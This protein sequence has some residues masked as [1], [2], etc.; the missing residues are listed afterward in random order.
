MYTTNKTQPYVTT[1]AQ[2]LANLDKKLHKHLHS[3]NWILVGFT[4]NGTTRYRSS[5]TD[6]SNCDLKNF[7]IRRHSA[8]YRTFTAKWFAWAFLWGIFVGLI[9]YYCVGCWMCVNYSQKVRFMAENDGIYTATEG[10]VTLNEY[11]RQRIP[12]ILVQIN[13]WVKCKHCVFAIY[14]TGHTH[15]HTLRTQS[16]FMQMM[17]ESMIRSYLSA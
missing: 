17:F 3:S 12:M 10:T 2:P 1:G 13:R 14:G 11:L 8:K 7:D 4:S 6:S 9:V 16:R 15:A 5:P